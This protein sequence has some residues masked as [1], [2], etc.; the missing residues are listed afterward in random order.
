MDAKGMR[1]MIIGL[2]VIIA[3]LVLLSGG[4]IED[5]EVFNY[6]MFNFQRL[7]AAPIVLLCGIIVE[8]TA[9]MKPIRKKSDK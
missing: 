4:G 5:P 3:G 2:L 9:I 7:V 8:I 1:L 6:E